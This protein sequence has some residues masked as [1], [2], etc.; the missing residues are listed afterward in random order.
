[1]KIFDI[2][3]SRL[4]D[5]ANPDY[6]L[7]LGIGCEVGLKTLGLL[8]EYRYSIGF[9]DLHLA[10]GN[11]LYH[12]PEIELRNLDHSIYLGIYF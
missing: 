1:M 6:G 5:L 8:L 10:T 12:F 2:I 4:D 7:T 9:S 11:P 3:R